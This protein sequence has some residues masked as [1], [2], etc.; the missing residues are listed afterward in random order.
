MNFLYYGLQGMLIG[1]LCGQSGLTV[2][3]GWFY[4][5][6]LLN[7]VLIMGIRASNE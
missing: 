4:F 6:L 7:S 5:V 2:Y 3:S 1:F